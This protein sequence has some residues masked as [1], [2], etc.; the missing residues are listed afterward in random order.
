MI[1]ALCMVKKTVLF[2]TFFF[3]IFVGFGQTVSAKNKLS[4]TTVQNRTENI[5]ERDTSNVAMDSIYN[6]LKEEFVMSN[7]DFDIDFDDDNVSSTQTISW[8]LSSNGDIYSRLANYSFSP[9]RFRIR[10]YA[11]EF[12]KTYMNGIYFN[13]LERG[14]F[15]FSSLGGLNYATRNKEVT[16]GM[17]STSYSFGNIGTTTNI[18]V[19]ASAFAKGQNLS[20]A[21]T[22][23]SYVARLQYT[24]ATGLMPN[25]WAFMGSMVARWSNLRIEQSNFFK[26]GLVYKS[27]GYFFSV[28]K[29]INDRHS[30]SFSTFGAPTERS[31]Q[32]AVTKEVTDLV[33][34]INY[35]AYL[36]Y[37]NGKQRNSRMIHSFDPTELLSYEWK[38]SENQN[39]K[40]GLASHYSKYSNNKF[41]F[42]NSVDPRPDY[43]RFM[44]S[45]F[46]DT[47]YYLDDDGNQQLEETH[48]NVEGRTELEKIWSDRNNQ[49]TQVNFDQ[50]YQANYRNNVLND[51]TAK[52]IL[53]RS[54]NDLAEMALNANYK[55]QFTEKLKFTAGVETKLSKGIHYA[56]IEDLLGAEKWKDIDVFAER[57][58]T[59]GTLPPNAAYVRLNN[60]GGDSIV[61][62]G[63]KFGYDYDINI[64]HLSAYLQNDWNFRN[65]EL[66]YALQLT[67]T[68]FYR[69][70]RMLNGRAELLSEMLGTPVI[71]KGKGY[72][73][74]FLDPAFKA[75]VTWKI[76]GRN[77]VQANILAQTQAPLAYNA[78][79][80]AK[81]KD[82]QIKN[83]CSE[84]V[85]SADLAYNFSF[86]R[87]LGRISGFYTS[88]SDAIET[89]GYYDDENRTFINMSMSGVDK[90]FYGVEEGVSVKLNKYFTLV[91]ACT[92]SDYSYT[93]NAHIVL[94]AENG[95]DITGQNYLGGTIDKETKAMIKGLKVA[96]GPQIAG[97]LGIKFFHP[98]MW[99]ADITV[100]YFDKNYF[101]FSPSH[102]TEDLYG[103]GTEGDPNQW[104]KYGADIAVMNNDGEIVR[105]KPS[106]ARQ[107]L[108]TQEK[109]NTDLK[110]KFML[111]FSV[112][113][114][115]YLKNR[116]SLSINLS[117]NN[118]LNSRIITGGYQQGRVPMVTSGNVTDLSTNYNKY[119]SKYYY[120]NGINFYL[121]IGYK[122]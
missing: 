51:S 7:F 117:V 54:H 50:M 104:G 105:Y 53:A 67:Y 76:N 6:Q 39:F 61:H 24:Y 72:T 34:S 26:E 65:V 2:P 16:R 62:T 44:P 41:E 38:I 63:D 110:S 122:F 114:L 25:G 119:P 12:Q 31:S 46:N 36:G 87:V 35:N 83:L 21:L 111:D 102:Y 88:M 66:Y 89:S 75:G 113:K 79:V 99:F 9:L 78:Y 86:P 73:R 5:A 56:T 85:I 23:R 18:D 29:R 27:A 94:S 74:Y 91:A 93:D 68:D 22:N 52:Y 40:A 81:I 4:E 48:V 47:H 45:N 8:L 32:A 15:N 59:S 115:I 64:K 10:G 43:Y 90:R 60:I 121:S 106:A 58:L 14:N 30:I 95:S 37:Q 42:N 101:N 107:V 3:I 77:I 120:A 80:S 92:L 69:F 118:L 11:A 55:N 103:N 13:G 28:E 33:G 17:E 97:S 96:A 100:N 116:N 109:I 49:V 1:K 70:G 84:K 57:D 19:R 112:G 108:G 71:S 82:T 98:K 20:M